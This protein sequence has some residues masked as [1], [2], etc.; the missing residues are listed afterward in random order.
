MP[1]YSSLVIDHIDRELATPQGQLNAATSMSTKTAANSTATP[2]MM[3]LR[4]FTQIEMSGKN[5]AITKK[6][7]LAQ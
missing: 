3:N 5:I 4:C 2:S 1:L 7:V 6:L